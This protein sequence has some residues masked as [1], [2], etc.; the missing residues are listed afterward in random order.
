MPAQL[1]SDSATRTTFRAL[2]ELLKSSGFDN[3]PR[4]VAQV[5][6][7]SM[8]HAR[9]TGWA[10]HTPPTVLS[11]E[12][13]AKAMDIEH[14]WILSRSGIRDRPP[15]VQHSDHRMRGEAT[16]AADGALPK[17]LGS[18]RRPFQIRGKGLKT[19][20][21][22]MRPDSRVETAGSHTRK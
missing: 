7:R 12:R 4:E 3:L 13:P 15:P 2:E 14:D 22:E 9:I 11:N 17:L 8:S 5:R 18:I 21:P 19:R 20:R 16:P 10:R 6:S 1:M